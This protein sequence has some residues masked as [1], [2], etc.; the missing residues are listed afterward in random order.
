MG[1]ELALKDLLLKV[2]ETGASDLHLS[3]GEKPS[4]R[5]EGQISSLGQMPVLSSD[6][7][8]ALCYSLLSEKQQAL[9]EENKNLDFSFG[10]KNLARFRVNLFFQKAQ[11][12]AVMRTIPHV[13]PDQSLLGLP[14]SINSLVNIP[15]GLVLISGPTGSGK[16]TTIATLIDKINKEQ[17]KHIVT[18]E[19]PI[20]FYHFSQQS[21]V[22]QREVGS[23][24]D[25]FSS[26]LKYALRQDPDV[27]LIGELRDLETVEM[28]LRLAET[29]HLVFSTIHAGSA[30]DSLIRL[31]DSFPS[32]AQN[33]V[34][35]QL[36]FVLKAVVNQ[37]LVIDVSGKNTMAT[38][39]LFMNDGIKNLLRENK[40][41]QIYS[42][43]QLGQTETKMHTMNQS[44]L[45]LVQR[46][47]LDMQRALYYSPNKK[48][49]QSLL[50]K[51]VA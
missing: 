27:C 36:S 48:E 14:L 32:N 35:T 45:R 19:D 23:D 26:A 18:V 20:E 33:K 2:L 12:G 44:L 31:I 10:V 1:T 38:E 30:V 47:K 17:A 51:A 9:F 16:S 34:R 50:L 21:I 15:S 49:L 8:R 6:E 28:G 13:I 29:G 39:M 4:V 22:T 24:V 11:V 43:M 25:D 42:L 3:A 41:H 7:I 46:G 40:L 37:Q 5:I